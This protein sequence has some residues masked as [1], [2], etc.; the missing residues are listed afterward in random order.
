MC[1]GQAL[2]SG[3][4]WGKTKL[5]PHRT[6]LQRELHMELKDV[7]SPGCMWPCSRGREPS[8][9]PD[10]F[11]EARKCTKH[12]SMKDSSSQMQWEN[13]FFKNSCLPES[14]H[15]QLNHGLLSSFPFT[16]PSHQAPITLTPPSP[17]SC[18][19]YYSHRPFFSTLNIFHALSLVLPRDF[20]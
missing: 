5:L 2:F 18:F 4:Q 3:I 19:P 1:C 11:L 13:T 16:I 14:V 17:I 10:T 9:K 8:E 20:G 7:S 6:L 15:W 12:M